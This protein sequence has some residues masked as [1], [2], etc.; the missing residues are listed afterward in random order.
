MNL[1]SINSNKW[2]RRVAWTAAGV[3]LL[4]GI[5]WLAVPPILKSQAQKIASEQLGRKV[6]IGAVDFKPWTLELTVTDLAVATADGA[7]QQLHVQRLYIDGELQS[8]L[9]LA[10]VVDAVT[11]DAPSLKLTRLSEGHYDIDDILARLSQPSGKPP[12]KPLHFALYNLALDGGSVDF[13]DKSV[14]KTHQLRDLTLSVPFLSNLDSKRGVVVQP[15]LAFTLNGSRFDSAAEGTPFA[16]THKLD[17]TIKLAG[18]DL[19]PYLGYIPASLPVRLQTGVIDTDL[20]V[21]FEQ[22]STT[23]VKLRGT[24][25]AS[26]VKLTDAKT[27]DLL[28]FD[29]LKL[30]L[31][32]VQPLAQRANISSIELTGPNVAVRRDAAGRFNVDLAATPAAASTAPVATERGAKG[33]D[34][35]GAAAT[36]EAQTNA[37]KIQVDKVAVRGGTVA[38]T[39]ETTA[40]HAQLALRELVFDAAAIALPFAK[41]LQFS[42]SAVLASVT[43][44]P[45]ASAAAAPASPSPQAASLSFGGAATDRMVSVAAN[46]KALPLSLAA[47]YLASFIEPGLNGQLTAQLNADWKAPAA[48]AQATGLL[49]GVKQLT[50]ENLALT[51]GKAV[52]QPRAPNPRNAALPS[53]KQIEVADARID[54]DKQTVS[55]GKLALT[56]PHASVERGA[57]KRWMFERWLKKPAASG[58]PRGSASKRPV[59]PAR[60]WQIAINDVAIEGGAVSYRDAAMPRPVAFEVSKLTIQLKDFALDSQKPSPLTASARIGAGRTEPGR[61]DYHGDLGLNPLSA[62]GQVQAVRL[63]LHALEPYFGDALNIRLLRADTSFKGQVHYL[64]SKAGPVVKVTGDSALE[65]FR[66]NSVLP[67]GVAAVAATSPATAGAVPKA[68]TMAAA[69]SLQPVSEPLLQWKAL[70][71]RGLDLTMKPGTAT[72]VNVRQTALSDFYARVIINP[73]GRIN[74]QDLVKSSAQPVAAAAPA[75]GAAPIK[76]APAVSPAPA[77]GGALAPIVNIGPISLVNGKVLFSDHFIKPNYSAD[78]TELT[79]KL[80]AFSS[81]A[82]ASAPTMAD[83]ELRGKAEGTA[84]LEITGKLNPLAK[85]LALDITGKVRDLELPPL[86]PYAIKYAGHG[87]ERGKMSLDVNYVVLPNGQL[88]AKNNLVLNQLSF[89]D[90]V[91][92]APTSLPVKLAVALLADR[93]GVINLDLPIS[94]SLNDPQFSLG[95][96]IFKAIINIIVKAVTAPFS[97]LANAFG[98]G[99]DELSTVAFAPGS[100]VLTPDARQSLDKVAKALAERP[101]LKMTVVGTAS[102]DAE[103]EGYRRERLNAMVRAEKRRE[104]TIGASA[105]PAPAAAASAA[106]GAAAPATTVGDAEYPALLKQVYKHADLPK[107]RNLIGMAKDL[108]QAEMESLLM[109][110]IPVTEDAMRQL[111]LARGEA[112]KEYLAL[113]QVPAQQLFLGAPKAAADQP[114]TESKPG[115]K[116]SPHADLNLATR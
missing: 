85:P 19:A 105:V 42:G 102:L 29:A 30:T 15:R 93:N 6:T 88:T 3:V 78:L 28:S 24:V 68:T 14:G 92:G 90:E 17:A 12:G 49:L 71:V 112:V 111:A 99:G 8:I 115:A 27:R 64:E 97:L 10:P 114:A 86:S 4:W 103:M 35:T 38:W 108:P 11:V 58:A 21:A 107:P 104:T 79:G 116:W 37:W 70:S 53:I 32:D 67:P 13:T 89:G 25:Q 40:P 63:P 65:D 83:L 60:T 73:N 82:P 84:S 1:Q 51:D 81:V 47:P 94:G 74:L 75:S 95:P 106:A 43:G 110:N 76:P 20:R 91:K 41:P 100:A 69:G 7:G 18:F 54:L 101:A 96:I 44:S 34:T 22:T 48:G 33:E 36:K 57:D 2:A 45:T 80:S 109:A 9:R 66:A 46:L 72:R 77:A 31:A 52:S 55:V 98:G 5:C 61:L 16:Q 87:I 50:L 26:H 59:A 56:D 39:D 62:Q 113:R 23:S